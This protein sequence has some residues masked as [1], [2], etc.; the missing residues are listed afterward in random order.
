MALHKLTPMK[1]TFER[2]HERGTR[3]V[4]ISLRRSIEAGVRIA[5][6]LFFFEV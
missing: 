6:D 5:I 4:Q 2:K 3:V 1:K